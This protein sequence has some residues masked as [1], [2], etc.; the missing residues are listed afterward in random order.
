MELSIQTA[1]LFERYGM[2][3][4]CQIIKNAGFTAVELQLDYAWLS[5]NVY[6]G[7]LP[8]ENIF[9][10]PIEDVVAFYKNDIDIIKKNG[11]KPIQAHAPFPAYV[12]DHPEILDYAIN[13][14]KKCIEYCN[15]IGVKNLVIHGISRPR[16]CALSYEQVHE[17]NVKLYSSLIPSLE[18][19]NVTVCLENLFTTHSGHDSIEGICSDPYEAVMYI[20]MFNGMCKDGVEHFGL[21]LDTGHLHLI[22]GEFYQ[23]ITILGNRIKCTHIHDNNGYYDEHLAPYAGTIEWNRFIQGF[24]S[25]DYKGYFSVETFNHYSTWKKSLPEELVIPMVNTIGVMVKYFADAV[26]GKENK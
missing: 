17:L 1:G 3:K 12:F 8:K 26:E 11:L 18:G 13:T 22:R 9:D 21:C 20:D 5:G 4:A 10:K 15:I 14:Y 25:I 19:T 23:Y 7:Q 24:K 6:N 16:G 2:D